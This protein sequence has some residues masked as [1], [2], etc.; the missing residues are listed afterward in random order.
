MSDLAKLDTET[1]RALDIARE[2]AAAGVPIFLAEPDPGH[3]FGYRLP[4]R[5]QQT[6]ANPAALD[7]WRPGMAVCAVGGHLADFV[8]CDPRNGGD[9]SAA[10]LRAGGGYPRSYGQ[11]STPSGGTHDLIVPLGTGSR[12]DVMPGLD[13]KGGRPD[14]EGRGFVALAPTVRKSK[15]TGE[16]LAY[17]WTAEPDLAALAESAGIDDSG[18]TL[19]GKIAASRAQPAAYAPPPEPVGGIE[20]LGTAAPA[21]RTRTAAEAMQYAGEQLALLTAA[22]DGSVRKTLSAVALRLGQYQHH[23]WPAEVIEEMLIKALWSGGVY[24]AASWQAEPCIREILAKKAREQQV[25]RQEPPAAISNPQPVVEGSAA[26]VD[27]NA[28][29]DWAALWAADHTAVQWLPGRLAERG[30][31]VALVGAGKAGKSLVVLDWVRCAVAGLPFLGDEA[32]KPIRVL[33]AD[34]ENSRRDI[35]TRLVAL[36]AQGP[37]DMAGL[38]YHS[39]PMWAALDT[40]KGAAEFLATVAAEYER[41]PIDLVILDTASRYIAGKENDSDTWIALYQLVQAHLKAAD[42]AGWRLDHFGKDDTVGARGS[43]AKAQDVDHVWELRVTGTSESPGADG[44]GPVVQT[45]LELKRTHTRSGLGAELVT[46]SRTGQFADEKREAWIAGGTRHEVS[47]QEGIPG[48]GT[49]ARRDPWEGDESDTAEAAAVLVGIFRRTFSEGNGGTKLE[50]KGLAV[51]SVTN[52]AG[53]M[54]KATFYQGWNRLIQEA[55]LA[56]VAGTQSYKWI[57]LESRGELTE[58]NKSGEFVVD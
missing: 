27:R 38:V 37:Q 23:F 15:V 1:A 39:F 10:E 22:Q 12:D 41:A 25:Q 13:V 31:Q 20:G 16:L 29:L 26:P 44:L 11:Q 4:G 3:S 42:I 18:G 19:A 2:L 30:Q 14:G 53:R 34:R 47:G 32:R 9:G 48:L 52:P 28:P 40:A 56:R 33:Y 55:V 51:K 57:P 43:V 17:R 5:W 49:V 24:D 7:H 6:V 58:R 50:A 45:G 36:G 35:F 8:D 21:E 46:F 54:S